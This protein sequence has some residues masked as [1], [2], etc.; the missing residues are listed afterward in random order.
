MKTLVEQYRAL[1]DSGALEFDQA[2]ALLIEKLQILSNRLSTYSP[3]RHTDFL[4]YFTRQRG[5]VPKGLYIFGKVGR[6]K[7]LAMD[8]FFKTVRFEPKRRYHF[9]EFMLEVHRRIAIAREK[10]D[11]DPIKHVARSISNEAALLC[12]DEL[13]VSDITDAMVLGRLFQRL[14]KSEVIIVSTSNTH[15]AELYKDGLNRQLFLPFIELIEDHLE[16]YEL[17]AHLDYRL[18]KLAHQQLYFTPLG[19]DAKAAM[20]TA[21]KNLT[22]RKGGFVAE[23]DLG[24]RLLHVPQ[25]AMGCAR[26]S[27]GIF[28]PFIELI[29]DHLEVY[30]L[31]AH[32]DYRLEK[33]AHQQLYFTPLGE[34]AKAAMDTAWKNLT[35]RKGGFV[36]EHDLGGRLLHV[37]QTAMGCAR[38][39]FQ[40]I[41][42]RPLGAE[43]Y[44]MLARTYQTIFIDNIP[45]LAADERN[46]VR[47][48]INLI[49]TLYD[50]RVKLV[51][52]AEVEPDKLY[53]SGKWVEHFERTASRLVEMRSEE[54]LAAPHGQAPGPQ[55]HIKMFE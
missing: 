30:E 12:F 40:E 16:V 47:R 9:H 11:G 19:E 34:D 41:C 45:V 20:D 23:H 33:L 21:W 37:P 53:P 51:I 14:L 44:L 39:S 38:F 1:L 17:A 4:F 3:P 5:E 48:F 29:E 50:N 55:T 46:E 35:G 24:G 43:D 42:G 8:M 36:A 26:F 28:L 32:L 22:G 52:S 25:T 15:P 27:F 2:Q 18:E 31:A 54:Y 7:T 13:H 6:G 10:Y 49:D